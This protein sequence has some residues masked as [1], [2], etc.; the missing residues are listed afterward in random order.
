[1]IALDH[2]SVAGAPEGLEVEGHRVMLDRSYL[3]VGHAG[4]PLLFLRPEADQA[5]DGAAAIRA[6]ARLLGRAPRPYR[7]GDGEWLDLDL[8][9]PVALTRRVDRDDWPPARPGAPRL[10]V[11]RLRGDAAALLDTLEALGGPPPGLVVDH[12]P[13]EPL[14]VTAVVLSGGLRV[15]L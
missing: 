3:E 8:A 4:E 7:G 2:V 6:A 1:M 11:V 13:G 9:G 10:A 15:P 5:G 12:A 14:R